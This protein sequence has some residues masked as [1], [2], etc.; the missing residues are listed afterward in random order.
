MLSIALIS[1]RP[2]PIEGHN[3]RRVHAF[4]FENAK[5][6]GLLAAIA[7]KNDLSADFQLRGDLRNGLLPVRTDHIS[8]P[9]AKPLA[10]LVSSCVHCF[11]LILDRK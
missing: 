11:S 3:Q 9:K 10:L 2:E 6:F 8:E 1:A 4:H 7:Q 5:L